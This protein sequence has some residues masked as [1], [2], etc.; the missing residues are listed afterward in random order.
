MKE[1]IEK[2]FARNLDRVESLLQLYP[3][4]GPGRRA[5]GASDLLRSA[6]VFLHATTED[7]IRSILEWKL[8]LAR[9]E[10]FAEMP[11]V[12]LKRNKFNLEDLAAHRGKSVD[13]VL[14]ESLV[15]SLQDSNFNSPGEVVRALQQVGLPSTFVD[16]YRDDLGPM[17][18]RRHWIVHRAD[19]NQDSGSGQHSVQSI[20][21]PTVKTWLRAVRGF[22]DVVLKES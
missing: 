3:N 17:M 4:D 8:P 16:P 10:A 22:G 15:A 12:G 21:L 5:V 18:K 20:A 6:V 7:L 2:R 13:E 11:L 1:D 9:N 19:R 14:R